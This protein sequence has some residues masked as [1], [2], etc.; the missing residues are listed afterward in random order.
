MAD[1]HLSELTYSEVR[2]DT[3]VSQDQKT[4][5]L[6][7][8]T[9]GTMITLLVHRGRSDIA[10]TLAAVVNA[11]IEYDSDS[12]SRDLWLEHQPEDKES[13][14]SSIEGWRQ[15]FDEVVERKRF[16]L[17]WLG[18]REIMPPVPF[19]WR[20][21]L[22]GSEQNGKRP[23]NHA[24]KVRTMSAFAQDWLAF[25]NDGE[26]Q[27]YCALKKIQESVLPREETIGIFP[28]AGGRIPGHTWEPDFLVTYKGRAGVLEVDGPHHTNR[29]ALDTT[30]EHLLRDAGVA[31]VDRI[32]VE[33][34]RDPDELNGAL[35]RFLRRLSETR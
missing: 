19:G 29:R 33:S 4:E 3:T 5:K 30:R 28:L 31:Y 35:R 20:K 1:Q 10:N 2:D 13:F 15:V 6:I 23:T 27:V 18:T 24:R 8:E 25:T 12:H 22:A 17:D 9:L 11:R 21:I 34:L 32:M 26:L 7:D 14:Q 16:P